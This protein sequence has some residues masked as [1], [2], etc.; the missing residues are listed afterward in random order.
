EFV[1][2]DEALAQQVLLHPQRPALVIGGREIDRGRQHLLRGARHVDVP[3]T[4]VGY[5]ALHCQH[6]SL[7][8]GVEHRL[9]RLRLHRPEAVHAA[10]VMYAVHD[11]SPAGRFGW[12]VPIMQSRVTRS[13]NRS[14]LQPS[15]PAGRMGTTMNRVSAVESHTRISVSAGSATPKS[16]STPRGSDT[17]RER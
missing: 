5:G 12:P 7:P 11:D 6:A 10:H 16:A 8:G 1:D 17:A 14:S 15:V 9:V 13:A 3:G 2:A 4:R